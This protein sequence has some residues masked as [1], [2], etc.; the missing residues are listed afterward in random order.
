MAQRSRVMV[1][2]HG[3]DNRHGNTSKVEFNAARL[4]A[5]SIIVV[6]AA[7]RLNIMG[8]LALPGMKR[9]APETLRASTP[10]RR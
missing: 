1:Y 7:D 10:W 3:G 2:Y 9:R 5:K 6:S 4:A 8:F